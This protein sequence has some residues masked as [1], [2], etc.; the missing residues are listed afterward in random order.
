MLWRR[1][2]TVIVLL[3]LLF[4]ILM[5]PVWLL[6]L[7]LVLVAALGLREYSLFAQPCRLDYIPALLLTVVLLFTALVKVELFSLLLTAVLLIFFIYYLFFSSSAR[8]VMAMGTALLGAFY[9]GWLLRY[10]L[11]LHEIGLHYLWLALIITWSNDI[12]S[13]FIGKRLGR[14]KLAPSLS[15]KKSIEG[16]LGGLLG[17]LLAVLVAGPLLGITG[18]KT[19]PGAL[20]V[21][22]SGQLGDLFESRMKR[23]AGVKDSG[24]LLPGH[25]GILDRIDSMLF[26]LPVF[27][28]LMVFNL[29]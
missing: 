6:A 3:P 27:Y 18:W 14:H 22:L 21:A 29:F 7:L 25:G 4:F 23:A 9:L 13:Y 16:A 24:Q 5:G 20:I 26:S 28:Y 10:P 8:V 2:L 11:L 15:P 12:F 19:I 17:A 1:V